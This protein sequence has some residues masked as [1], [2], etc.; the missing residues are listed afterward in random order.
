MQD[1]ED[2]NYNQR[3]Q[4][5]FDSFKHFSTVSIAT[6]AIVLAVYREGYDQTAIIIALVCFAFSLLL[7]LIGMSEIA[8]NYTNFSSSE[9][10]LRFFLRA[11]YWLVGTGVSIILLSAETLASVIMAGLVALI[12]TLWLVMKAIKLFK[13]S[14]RG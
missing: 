8:E 10:L 3:I 6:S 7:S 9:Q 13:G 2:S 11:C 5:L 14:Q 4:L 1:R 12:V